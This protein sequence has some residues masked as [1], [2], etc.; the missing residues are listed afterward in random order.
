MRVSLALL[1][2]R[3]VHW[4]SNTRGVKNRRRRRLLRVLSVE[5]FL[6]PYRLNA[7]NRTKWI[8]ESAER[9][10]A[11]TQSTGSLTGRVKVKGD[12]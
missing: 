6:R 8:A 4:P 12:E 3:V 9:E 2:G 5:D 10:L 7:W 11:V 1:S